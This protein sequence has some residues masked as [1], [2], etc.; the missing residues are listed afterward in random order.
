MKHQVEELTN[1]LVLFKHI[2]SSW[3]SSLNLW[4]RD[5]ESWCF[6]EVACHLLDE[7]RED[8]RLRLQTVFD[9]A[10]DEFI[11]I[12]PVGWVKDRN[13]I[14]Q[15]FDKVVNDFYNE[16]EASLEYLN[17]LR[18]NDPNWS[19]I[20]E[21]PLF[22]SISPMYFLDNWLAHDYLHIRQLTRIKYDHLASISN[23]SIDY[24]GNWV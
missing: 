10:S 1:N 13:Y 2:F 21:H 9:G 4:K 15:D 16:R 14:N 20:I 5:A 22:K 11:P 18:Q 6:L 23:D 8:F 7:E 3:D 19:N 24:A 12:D 17:S